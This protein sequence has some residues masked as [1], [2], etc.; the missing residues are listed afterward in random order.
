MTQHLAEPQ[1]QD[2]LELGTC[3]VGI[4]LL[5]FNDFQNCTV[6]CTYFLRSEVWWSVLGCDNV[7]LRSPVSY[8]E[9]LQAAPTSAF[10]NTYCTIAGHHVDVC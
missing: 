9:Y 6:D 10:S 4:V 8:Q 2:T 1:S 5:I 7:R 3:K